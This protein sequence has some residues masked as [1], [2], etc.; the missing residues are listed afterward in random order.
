M[1]CMKRLLFV[2]AF[3]TALC[4]FLILF[5]QDYTS[6]FYPH[7]NA[8]AAS[9]GVRTPVSVGYDFPYVL[10]LD[11]SSVVMARPGASERN[12]PIATGGAHIEGGVFDR[13]EVRIEVFPGAMPLSM[14]IEDVLID[15]ERA[16]VRG[17]LTYEGVTTEIEARGSV[18]GL[19]DD[20]YLDLQ[21][22]VPDE[23]KMRVEEQE[24]R[25]IL[26]LFLHFVPRR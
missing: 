12:L 14:Q 15:E 24:T 1:S 4:A 9:G 11:H 19:K 10:D 26:T 20:V 2:S 7:V 21:F 23:L 6:V 8:Y 16:L 18:D 5:T 17:T 22:L 3:F 13:G 25:S